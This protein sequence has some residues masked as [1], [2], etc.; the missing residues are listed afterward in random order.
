MVR[1]E[2]LKCKHNIWSFDNI[3]KFGLASFYKWKKKKKKKDEK[4]IFYRCKKIFIRL[5]GPNYC[6][7]RNVCYLL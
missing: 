1:K 6:H 3:E 5:V 4:H 2:K 7:S